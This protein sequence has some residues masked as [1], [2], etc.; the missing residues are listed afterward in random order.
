[1]INSFYT[2]SN[3]LKDKDFEDIDDDFSK[4]I[5]QDNI[6]I[7]IFITIIAIIFIIGIGFLIKTLFFS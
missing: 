2:S 3:A 4:S 5:E 6:G 1:M 7:K